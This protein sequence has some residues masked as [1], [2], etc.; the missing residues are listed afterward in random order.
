MWNFCVLL[1]FHFES[2]PKCTLSIYKYTDSCVML[3][4]TNKEAQFGLNLNETDLSYSKLQGIWALVQNKVCSQKC[5]HLG[6]KMCT[7]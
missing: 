1:F 5:A 4:I 2:V 3:T 6:I 7:T